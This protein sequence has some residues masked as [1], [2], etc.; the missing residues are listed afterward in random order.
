MREET[1][2]AVSRTTVGQPPA[3]ETGDAAAARVSS[4]A[5]A[6]ANCGEEWR[7]QFCYACG[8]KRVDGRDLSFRH[9][10]R[11]AF[12]EV[13]DFEHSKF[14]RTVYGL[15]LR[16]GFLTEEYFA[17]RKGR[18]YTPL[19]LFITVFALS[20]LIYTLHKNTSVYNVEMLIQADP[21]G[22]TQRTFEELAK[23]K[24]VEPS[25]FYER[26]NERLQKY[27]TTSQHLPVVLLS[28]F[29]VFLY[30]D[31]YFAEHLV[32]SLHLMSFA[33][34]LGVLM[35]PLVL[36]LGIQSPLILTT[37]Y[38][39]YAVYFFLALKRFYRQSARMTL[40]K[41]LMLYVCYIVALMMTFYGV[42]ALAMINAL[43]AQ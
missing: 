2:V 34:A 20:F 11:N 27:T 19:K 43:R 16:P 36:W 1:A 33:Y 31:R 3:G 38:V 39:L 13:V 23:M 28:F 24:K 42:L 32:F 6:C 25:V 22:N 40:L 41:T 30:W 17:G 8:E 4:A 12:A 14:F 35:W 9:F 29:L 7:G 26:V 18:Y 15:L 37:S 10:V 21:Y 5:A